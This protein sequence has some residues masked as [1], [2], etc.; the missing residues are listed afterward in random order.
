MSKHRSL[1]RRCGTCCR[2][3]LLEVSGLD[4]LREPRWRPFIEPYRDIDYRDWWAAPDQVRFKVMSG[5]CPFLQD[6]SCTIYPQRPDM[7]VAFRPIKD[8]RCAHSPECIFDYGKE[9]DVT[10]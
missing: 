4:L 9:K 10:V 6:N 2:K 1:C 3:L 5:A 7:C 8:N